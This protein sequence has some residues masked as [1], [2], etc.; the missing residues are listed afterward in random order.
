MTIK[1]HNNL[2]V[3][4]N[5]VN[6][7]KIENYP[8]PHLYIRNFFEK[9]FYNNLILSIPK[10]EH[11]IQLNKTQNVNSNYPDER[12]VFD[13]TPDTF[14]SF[15]AEQK[16]VFREIVN[17]LMSKDF[18][19]TVVSKFLKVLVPINPEEIN[20]RLT[21]VKDFTNYN[22]GAH[23]DSTQKFMTFLFYLPDDDSNKYI[24]TTLYKMKEDSDL[25]ISYNEHFSA[26]DTKKHFKQIKL[27]E[28]Y[29]NSVL[30]FP[31]SNTSY[32]GVN[33]IDIDSKARNLLLLNY[34]HK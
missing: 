12:Y 33:P 4:I 27:A 26:E 21:L 14:N 11:F 10:K 25:K 13:I 24:G 8:F 34:Y 1:P 5:S 28:Y 7:S 29:P 16:N 32:H 15:N 2:K 17:I 22:L 30:V 6:K 19:L 31:R 23:T 9:S 3:I 18:F 20:I